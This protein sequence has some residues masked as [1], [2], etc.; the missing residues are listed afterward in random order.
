MNDRDTMLDSLVLRR[1]RQWASNH[2]RWYAYN[3]TTGELVTR[4][5]FKRKAA[6]Y[7]WLA[8]YQRALEGA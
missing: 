6:A 8:E 3:A 2:W 5:G 1:E 4:L 7:R